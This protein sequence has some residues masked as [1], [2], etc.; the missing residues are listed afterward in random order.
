METL[1]SKTKIAHSRR[2][3]CKKKDLKTKITKGDL[4]RGLK[5]F[6]D[7]NEVQ[8]RKGDLDK[9]IIEAMYM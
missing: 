2:V 4:K 9:K 6:M 5:M 8:S 7:N 1:F 3:F